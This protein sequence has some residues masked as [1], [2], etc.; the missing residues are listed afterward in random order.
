MTRHPA[1]RRVARATGWSALVVLFN[2]V[3][4]VGAQG[5]LA[6]YRPEILAH[7]PAAREMAVCDGAV[8]VGTKGDSIYMFPIAGGDAVPVATRLPAPNGVACTQDKLYVGT[9]DRILS[10]DVTSDHR[11]ANRK[12]LYDKL[13]SSGVHSYRYIQIGPDQRLYVSLGSPCNIC[14]P[15]GLQGTIISMALD[16]SDVKRVAWGVRNSVGF[17]WS[18]NTMYFTDNGADGMGDDIPPDELNE[19]QVG[20]FYGFPYFG[21]H[22]RLRGFAD[23]SPPAEPIFPVHEFQAHVATLGIHFYRGAMFPEL[24][25]EALVA[26]HGSWDRSTPVGYQVV[27]LR[28]GGADEKLVGDIGRPVDVKELPDGAIIISDDTGDRVW[29]LS[30]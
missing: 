3:A 22:V 27:H 10:F 18:G 16:G 25:G 21:G 15:Q 17:D 19:L 13:P 20:G 14:Q 8:F 26:E 5:A 23:A 28:V 7:V 11:L 6:S 29:R 4:I 12:D 24:R 1:F 9:R 30:R 2:L